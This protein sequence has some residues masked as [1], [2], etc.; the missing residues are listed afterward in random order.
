M[1]DNCRIK[2]KRS[3]SFRLLSVQSVCTLLVAASGLKA[4]TSSE[5]VTTRSG[6]YTDAQAERGRR[7]Y[8]G[9]CKLCHQPSTGVAFEKHWKGRS[10]G[11]LLS[12]MNAQ[13]PKNDPGSLEPSQYADIAAYLL[14]VNAMPAGTTELGSDP[15]TLTSVMIEMP[16]KPM[17]KKAPVKAKTP[18]RRKGSDS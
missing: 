1:T 5:L 17:K 14:K 10:V 13:M 2:E 15:S 3:C 11:D 9:T 12:F 18:I 16:R 4:Q 7:A 6:I 8:L